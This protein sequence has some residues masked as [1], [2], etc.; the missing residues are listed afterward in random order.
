MVKIYGS[1]FSTEAENNFVS[2][3][4]KVAEVITA[5][6]TMLEVKAP[7][8]SGEDV[9]VKV[10]VKGSEYWSDEVGFSFLDALSVV[11]EEIVWPNG[12][13]V[14]DSEN[15]YIGSADEGVIYK[16]APD[17]NKTEFAYESISGAMEFGPDN[18]LYVCEQGEG[19]I[20]RIS[21][22]GGTVEDVV[23]IESPIDF[24]WDSNQDMYIISNWIDAEEMGGIFR[25][26]SAGTLTQLVTL[27]SPKCIR[28][29][30]QNLYVS[31]IWD[32]QI[33]K[34]DITTGGLENEEVVYEG[35][36]P[37]GIEIDAEGTLYFTEAWETSLYTLTSDGDQEILYEDQLMTP[38]HYLTFYGKKMYIVY[39]GW[40][41][42]G[43]T[44]S[45]YIGVEQ[46][47]N[48]GRQ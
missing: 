2:F 15:V 38:M 1:G 34:Y 9:N 11:D 45:A 28:I 4:V 33:L 13:A 23:E 36:S 24:D 32:S 16:I 22:D 31:D 3:G 26:T 6:P 39:P 21:P 43:T 7:N 47:P 19:K 5:T 14:D 8:I 20:V 25:Y 41:D 44:M 12:V 48:Y 37:L 27:G 35:D 30:N 10:A 18:Y 46:A 29:F 42:V 17:G 40:G